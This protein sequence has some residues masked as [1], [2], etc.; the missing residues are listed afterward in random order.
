MERR[1]PLTNQANAAGPPSHATARTRDWLR[2]S[3]SS[4]GSST[5][6]LGERQHS[7]AE[8]PAFWDQQL[9]TYKFFTRHEMKRKVPAQLDA[10]D[11]TEDLIFVTIGG[12]DIGF[13]DIVGECLYWRKLAECET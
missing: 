5:N 12:N 11:G 9:Y 13:A 10:I 3:C 1:A 7:G 8:S 2:R 4:N 6:R